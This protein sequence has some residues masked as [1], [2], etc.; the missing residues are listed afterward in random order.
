[1]RRNSKINTEQAKSLARRKYYERQFDKWI[2]WRFEQFGY[3]K[4]K[5]I[6]KYSKKYNLS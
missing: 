2:K 6:I 1:M 4:Y 3:V 5:D